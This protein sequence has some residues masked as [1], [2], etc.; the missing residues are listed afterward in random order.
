MKSVCLS[1]VWLAAAPPMQASGLKHLRP[2]SK[3]ENK[4]PSD[5]GLKTPV[6]FTDVRHI[7]SPTS[8]GVL[9]S[10]QRAAWLDCVV[11]SQGP[12]AVGGDCMGIGRVDLDRSRCETARCPCSA[13]HPVSKSATTS[14]IQIKIKV[15]TARHSAMFHLAHTP[16]PC[17]ITTVCLGT[18]VLTIVMYSSQTAGV[19]HR[20]SLRTVV[21][22]AVLLSPVHLY[23]V[24]C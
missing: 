14:Q 17:G 13:L 24:G 23:G 9:Y 15:T 4:H 3:K 18:T 22:N 5:D 20:N 10:K 2:A 1:A 21:D 11:V 6:I 7:E 12:P 16:T 19:W 8:F